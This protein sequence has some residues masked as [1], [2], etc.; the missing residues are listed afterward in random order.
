MV[1][2]VIMFTMIAMVMVVIAAMVVMLVVD[3]TEGPDRTDKKNKTDILSQ[4]IIKPIELMCLNPSGYS[5]TSYWFRR[6][7]C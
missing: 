7:V 6:A 3:R 2:K 5:F 1:A 4:S